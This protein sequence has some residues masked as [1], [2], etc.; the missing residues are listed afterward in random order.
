M[1]YYLAYGS[2][3]NIHQMAFRCRHARVVGT[4]Y[5][6]GYRLMF[7]GSKTGSYLTIE[8]AKGYKVP[9]AVWE[10]NPA[11]ERSL[12]MYEGFPTFYYKKNFKLNVRLLSGGREELDCFAYIMDE[13]RPLGSPSSYYVNVCKEGYRTFGFDQKYLDDAYTYS[14]ASEGKSLELIKQLQDEG[15]YDLCPRCG[16][17]LGR[18]P[19][20]S[21]RYDIDIC[22]E[23]GTREALH[24]WYGLDDPVSEWHCF[25]AG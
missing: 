10:I 22:S 6:P 13:R 17:A 3:L 2:N 8:P 4:G 20:L 5:I 9:V 19:A 23:C 11:H 15:E 24:D 12:D 7:K 16:E 1:K 18:H 25:R 21:R 14:S